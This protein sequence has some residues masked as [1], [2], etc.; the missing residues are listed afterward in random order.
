MVWIDQANHRSRIARD[1]RL[2][3]IILH[4]LI[5][6]DPMLRCDTGKL[7]QAQGGTLLAAKSRLCL[8]QSCLRCSGFISW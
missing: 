6:D 7:P 3:V 5:R 1:D 8:R 4:I 2:N